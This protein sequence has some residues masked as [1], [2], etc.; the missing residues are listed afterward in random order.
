MTNN[1]W[2]DFTEQLTEIEK[3]MVDFFVNIIREK[4]EARPA[5]E[6]ILEIGSGWGLFSRSAME[7][8]LTSKVTTID[9]IPHPQLKEFMKHTEGYTER[10]R[11]LSGD[12]K[13]ILP[14]IRKKG[15]QFVFVD[16]DHSYEGALSDAR[17]AWENLED[18]GWMMFDDVLHKSNWK[19]E[20]KG[21][22]FGVARA[23]WDFVREKG[24]LKSEFYHYGTGGML[25][26]QKPKE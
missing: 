20:G 11:W 19:I 10:M 3:P 14:T 4:V 8:F 17:L 22:D 6:Q 13:E 7:A 23:F 18:G 21:F 24:I 12:S 5:G 16:G 9:K 26:I 25:L 2:R 15:F 1:M